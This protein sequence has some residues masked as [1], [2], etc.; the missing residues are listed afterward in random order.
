MKGKRLLKL[1]LIKDL[2]IDMIKISIPEE[3]QFNVDFINHNRVIKL[4]EDENSIVIAK[5]D[6]TNLD[7]INEIMHSYRKKNIKIE[8]L[9]SREFDELVRNFFKKDHSFVIQGKTKETLLNDL[10]KLSSDAPIVNLVNEIISTAI[11]IKASDVHIE[12]F[13]TYFRVRARVDGYLRIIST[14]PINLFEPVCARI[15][16]MSKLDITQKRVAQDGKAQLVL[17]GVKYD[18]RTSTL[19]TIFGESIVLR[20]LSTDRH[21]FE[22]LKSL[23]LHEDDVAV[24]MRVMKR[25]FGAFFLTGPTGSGKTT[26]LK[27]LLG[28]LDIESKNIITVEDP[29]EYTIE[30]I[31]QIQINEKVGLTFNTVLRNIL[32]QDPD[33]IMIGE[34]RDKETVDLALRSAIT[35]HLVLSTLHT[36]DSIASISRLVNMEVAPYILESAIIGAAAQRLVRVLCED[37][38]S[39]YTPEKIDSLLFEKHGLNTNLLYKPTGCQKCNNTGYVGRKAFFEIFETDEIIR[40]MIID[41]KPVSY[42]R[43]HLYSKGFKSIFKKGIEG[44]IEG[45]VY[46]E[47]VK[48]CIGEQNE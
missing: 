35:G 27:M 8:S 17:Y 42:I 10:T 25:S 28:L 3:L 38:K 34:M 43:K 44:A 45:S 13:E 36:N 5:D 24:L 15:K 26:T 39:K 30:G 7:V 48:S 4:S 47:E 16:V 40:Q 33:V 19:P 1:S 37:C 14:Y 32:R 20:F 22:S 18:I 9:T 31:N 2:N 29:V 46:L 23:G 12:P 41:N 11:N 6:S 21:R